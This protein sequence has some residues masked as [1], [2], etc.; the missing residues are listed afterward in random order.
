MPR[1]FEFTLCNGSRGPIQDTDSIV[2]LFWG[3]DPALHLWRRIAA[4]AAETTG[5]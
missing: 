3:Q 2:R 5:Y 1:K 4:P